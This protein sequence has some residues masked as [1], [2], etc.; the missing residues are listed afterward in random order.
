[1]ADE[2]GHPIWRNVRW[3]LE[4]KYFGYSCVL[5]PGKLIFAREKVRRKTTAHIKLTSVSG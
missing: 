4:G 3:Q 5:F 1:M 2:Y